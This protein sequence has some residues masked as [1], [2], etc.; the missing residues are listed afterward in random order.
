[1]GIRIR[2]ENNIVKSC[3]FI[4]FGVGS[5][6]LHECFQII[7]GPINNDG[8]GAQIIDNYFTLPGRKSNSTANHVPENTVVAVGGVDTL[9]KGNVFENMDFN[10]IN[11]QSPLHGISIGNTKNAKIID[12]TFINF[13]GACIYMDSWTNEDFIIKNNTADNVW[14]FLQMSCQH[15]DNSDQISFNKNLVLS[16]NKINLSIGDCYWHWNKP[17][18][19]SNFVGYVNSPN[20]DHIKYTGFENILITKNKVTL[21]YRK[22]NSAFEEST[23][24]FCFWGN[25]VGDDKIKMIN[26]EVTSSIPRPVTKS[27]F[28]KIIDFFKKLFH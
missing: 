24:L 8:R 25:S 15:W 14:Q 12:N 21:G 19:V 16:E 23:K 7:I 1:M 5:K 3:K 27:F 6:D 22:L 4:N 26:N 11:Q 2:G 9:V 10:V 28:E 13:Q 20:V 18:I 17:P